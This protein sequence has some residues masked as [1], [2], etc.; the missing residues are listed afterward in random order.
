MKI[1]IF[2]W[3]SDGDILPFIALAGGLKRSGHDISLSV[4]SVDAK[5]YEASAKEVGVE[6]SHVVY[7]Y[8]SNPNNLMR[9]CLS[10]TNPV[11][12]LEILVNSLYAPATELYLKEAVRLDCENELVIAHPFISPF[13]F[14]EDGLSGDHAV[15]LLCHNTIPSRHTP[16]YG[17]PNFGGWF[18]TLI[19]KLG[20]WMINRAFLKSINRARN[21]IGYAPVNDMLCRGMISS[22]LNLIAVSGVFAELMDDWDDTFQVCGHLTVPAVEQDWEPPDELVAFFDQGEP[23]V[24]F[25]LGTMV[26]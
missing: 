4:A 23:P 17:F 6:I 7:D 26:L 20:G 10:I 9:Q 2:T 19:W 14:K 25:N 18:N 8:P 24:L 22:K 15:V 1:G 11:K 16:F 5:N 12:Q 21:S 13:L 3:G